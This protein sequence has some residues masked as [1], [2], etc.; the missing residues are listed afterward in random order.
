[1]E[2]NR[3][4]MQPWVP[5]ISLLLA[6]LQALPS[7]AH[8]ILYRGIRKPIFELKGSYNEGDEIQVGWLPVCIH[9]HMIATNLVMLH[10]P[11]DWYTSG[12]R[13]LRRRLLLLFC[14]TRSP[15]FYLFLHAV[16]PS[17]LNTWSPILALTYRRSDVS[18]PD[19]SSHLVCGGAASTLQ[20]RHP[21]K[22][23]LFN[24]A[25]ICCIF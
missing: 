21:G 11:I 15:Y 13:F 2:K 5:Y 16:F 25:K 17:Q 9:L 4:L 24:S 20:P 7:A 3:D 10:L 12:P 14:K 8:R 23:L 1:M 6:C 19:W 18:R 22:I